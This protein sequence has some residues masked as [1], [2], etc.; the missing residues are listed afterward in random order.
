MPKKK[1][2]SGAH[3]DAPKK[4]TTLVLIRKGDRVLL[5]MKKRGFGAGRWNG[6]GGK[7]APGETILGAA[8]RELLEEVGITAK[9]MKKIAVIDFEFQNNP[10]IIEVNF[11]D[12]LE[13][14]GKPTEGEEMKPQW[15]A[16]DE[17]PF[18]AMWPDDAHWFP[19]YLAGKKFTGHFLFGPGDSIVWKRLEEADKI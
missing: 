17:I 14:T 6:F 11:F 8:K 19:L 10:E 2:K 18:R 15:F 1:K 4:V 9:K 7:V 12:A 16:I 3:A 13:W 5:G